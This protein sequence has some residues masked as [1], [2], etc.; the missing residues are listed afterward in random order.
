MAHKI[1]FV[2]DEQGVLD[3]YERLLHKEF[4]VSVAVGGQKGLSAL[5]EHGPFAVVIS[6]M[7]MPGMNGAEFLAEVR[8]RA[9][10]TI[11]MLLTGYTDLNA[12]ID[13]VNKGNI[14]QYLAKPC[15]KD[16]LIG[17][18]N[19]GLAQYRSVKAEKELL[20]KAQIAEPSQF[21]DAEICQWDN[22]ES[23]TGLPGPSQA[24]EHLAPLLGEDPQCYVVL[25][26][27]TLVRTIE[28]RYGEQAAAGY[29]NSGAQFLIQSLRPDDRFFHWGR[30]VLMA[31]VRRQVSPAALRMELARLLSNSREYV[32]EA[33]GRS[34][35]MAIPK[36]FDL[37]PAS[38]FS[39]IEDLLLAFDA[40][41][42]GRL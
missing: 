16:V 24:R 34:I 33:N 18:I 31:V 23:P 13:A 11:R 7:R 42:C 10:D 17:A 1:L 40:S 32:M 3:G 19:K 5:Q 22:F 20:K 38:Q 39:T 6:D 35:V 4:K 29:L 28:E 2:D 37:Q 30:D 8:Q 25:F 15:D 26:R 41:L 27:I 36:T 14:F 12:A 21:E 9:P